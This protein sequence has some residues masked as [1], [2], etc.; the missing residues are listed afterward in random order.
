MNTLDNI[1]KVAGGFVLIM[2]CAPLAHLDWQ[3]M[4]QS[5]RDATLGAWVPELNLDMD[6][7]QFKTLFQARG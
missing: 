3:L 5:M 7:T 1:L 4:I 6:L 2:I